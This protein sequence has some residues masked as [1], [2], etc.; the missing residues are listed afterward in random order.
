L[1]TTPFSV[2]KFRY[3][4]ASGLLFW[5]CLHVKVLHWYNF[6]L[7]AAI[8]ESL[9]TNLLLGFTCLLLSTMFRFYIPRRNRYVYLLAL[10]IVLTIMWFLA[11]RLLL[12]LFLNDYADYTHF[13]AQSVPVRLA[14]GYLVIGSMILLFVLWYALH[15]N[16]EN[17]QRKNEAERLAKEAELYNLRQQ[18]QPHFLFN[19]LN[20]INALIGFNTSQAR[21][22]IQQLSD[23]LRGTLKKD[24]NQLST[25]DE[26][27]SHLQ[28]YLD[29]EMV[30][31]GHRLNTVVA[32]NDACRQ[33]KLPALLLQPV[34]ENAIKF[35]LYD[36]VDDVTIS[37]KADCVDNELRIEV[38]NPFEPSSHTTK[39][40]TGFGLN[41]VKRRLYLV[42]A[43]QGLLQTNAANNIFTT[44]ISIPQAND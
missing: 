5:I 35:G 43:R 6:S 15:E 42:Y 29:I 30:R 28:L 23:F 32:C 9:V 33:M 18:L 8:T 38:I 36:T 19:S 10:S 7:K 26:E 40:G 13:F 2:K 17:E 37:I 12:M 22:M 14:I 16:H 39:S 34:V 20:S 11:S 44:I 21:T 3:F 1:S 41:S 25:L 24:N 4:F 31:F 27:L